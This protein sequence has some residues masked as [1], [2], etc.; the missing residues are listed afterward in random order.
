MLWIPCGSCFEPTSIS[1]FIMHPTLANM[2]P[3]EAFDSSNAAE[4]NPSTNISR[5]RD[6]SRRRILKT[7]AMLLG[8]LGY[9][10]TQFLSTDL[11]QAAFLVF[12]DGSVDGFHLD[13]MR[14]EEGS[15]VL[16]ATT[17]LQT[18]ELGDQNRTLP[19][20]PY[21]SVIGV[22]YWCLFPT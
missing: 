13:E 11:S 6:T 19:T 15:E 20:I 9:L 21:C 16:N 3:Q 18:C 10:F 4:A 2:P 17:E 22:C 12:Q 7:G 1:G 14:Q 8:L 5:S